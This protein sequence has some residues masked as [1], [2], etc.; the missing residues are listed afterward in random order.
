MRRTPQSIPFGPEGGATAMNELQQASPD[1]ICVRC[2]ADA[3]WSFA[4]QAQAL[5]EIVCPECGRFEI[6]RA[7]F[8]QAEFDTAQTEERR[9]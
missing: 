6:P 1:T 7:E 2:G 4:D 8:E 9:S 5:V 3:N